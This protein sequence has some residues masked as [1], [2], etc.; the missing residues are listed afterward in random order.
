M[1]LCSFPGCDAPLSGPTAVFCPDHHFACEPHEAR[2]LIGVKVKILRTDDD[3]IRKHLTGQL[4][5]YTATIIRH[6]QNRQGK[7]ENSAA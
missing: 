2:L 4:S 3:S 7:G 6:I 1:S 5:G